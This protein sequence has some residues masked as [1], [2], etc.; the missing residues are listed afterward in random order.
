[1]LPEEY[2]T[3]LSHIENNSNSVAHGI[4]QN[5]LKSGVLS[6]SGKP[7][8]ISSGKP[9]IPPPLVINGGGNH[10][11]GSIYERLSRPDLIPTPTPIAPPL[12]YKHTHS[13]SLIGEDSLPM[14]APRH[15][16]SRSLL[17]EEALKSPINSPGV[18]YN[19][20]LF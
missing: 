5:A 12:R 11:G 2:G 14:P 15:G 10:H 8:I 20:L 4:K 3:S 6:H 18:S 17:D 9:G 7:G 19:L 1:M 13:K 16:H